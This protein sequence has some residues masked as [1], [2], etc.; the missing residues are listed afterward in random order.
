[1]PKTTN[2][3]VIHPSNLEKFMARHGLS[4]DYSR[5]PRVG[6]LSARK[7]KHGDHVV[8]NKV[9]FKELGLSAEQMGRIFSGATEGGTAEDVL[10]SNLRQRRPLSAETRKVLAEALEQKIG[11]IVFNKEEIAWVANNF[12]LTYAHHA[13]GTVATDY[14]KGRRTAT[15]TEGMKAAY[16]RLL[17]EKSEN[18]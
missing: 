16:D 11:K 6:E 17:Q 14:A 2:V 18:K 7:V 9:Y 12:Y 1:M 8:L 10:L 3:P 15:L 5:H 13:N 4:P